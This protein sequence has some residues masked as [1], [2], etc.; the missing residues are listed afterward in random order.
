MHPVVGAFRTVATPMRLRGQ[1]LSPRGPAPDLGQHTR[2]V[3]DELGLSGPEVEALVAAGTV[4]DG[5]TTS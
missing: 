2:A 3:L 5:V 4:A 1:D